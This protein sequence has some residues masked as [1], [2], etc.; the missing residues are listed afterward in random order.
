MEYVRV[1]NALVPKRRL[2]EVTGRKF[3]MSDIPTMRGVMHRPDELR[4][5][6]LGP[7]LPRV[8]QHDGPPR[9]GDGSHARPP[10]P[11]EVRRMTDILPRWLRELHAALLED[12][13]LI[14]MSKLLEAAD[15]IERLRVALKTLGVIGN[16]YCFCSH[17][18]ARD[19]ATHEPECR[20]ARA[21][22]EGK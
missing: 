7:E 17:D 10:N 2:G 11:R 9:D 3:K 8:P 12:G 13:F 6:L 22:S 1:L 21:A 18:R 15:E 4:Q 16:G 5:Q 19:R 20:D 14:R